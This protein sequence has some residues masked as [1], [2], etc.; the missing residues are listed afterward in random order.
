V[1]GTSVTLA[2]LENLAMG[3]EGSGALRAQLDQASRL[4]E[5]RWEFKRKYGTEPTP[6]DYAKFA[7]YAGPA[8]LNWE[9]TLAENMAEVGPDIFET[10]NK[11]YTNNPL[12]EAQLKVMLGDMKGSGELKYQLKEA[13]EVVKKEEMAH[14]AGFTTPGV[15]IM[16]SGAPSGGFKLSMPG[17]EDL[18]PS[19]N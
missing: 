5:Y 13:Q 1:L 10:W 3:G 11:V 8:E 15:N 14:D 19:M 4:D 18:V 2:D 6:T 17:I 9:L 7:G 12:T 16:F